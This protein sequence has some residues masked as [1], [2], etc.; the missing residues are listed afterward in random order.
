MSMSHAQ[1]NMPI[2]GVGMQ[3]G[4]AP[5]H[6]MPPSAGG[7]HHTQTHAPAEGG[8]P[9]LPQ[10]QG[11]APS[12]MQ[13]HD[14]GPAHHAA[15]SHASHGSDAG[16]MQMVNGQMQ[17]VGGGKRSMPFTKTLELAATIY[18]PAGLINSS[19]QSA[20]VATRLASLALPDAKILSNIVPQPSFNGL[21]NLSNPAFVKESMSKGVNLGIAAIRGL[22]KLFTFGKVPIA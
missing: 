6:N 2:N 7:S 5:I 3:M 9:T 11:H 14:S 20:G 18:A 1:P 19:Y 4:Q 15:A 8:F 16:Q 21:T 22:A 10:S 12:A 13:G 17:R